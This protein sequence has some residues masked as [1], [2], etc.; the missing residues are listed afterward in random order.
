MSRG[1]FRDVSLEGAMAVKGQID[2]ISAGSRDWLS[3][4]QRQYAGHTLFK[5][6]TGSGLLNARKSRSGLIK[7]K[8]I[9][10]EEQPKFLMGLDLGRRSFDDCFLMECAKFDR[11]TEI[12]V[13]RLLKGKFPDVKLQNLRKKIGD[14]LG[15][16]SVS[17]PQRNALIVLLNYIDA[18]GSIVLGYS[19]DV[20]T[21]T[22][23]DGRSIPAVGWPLWSVPSIGSMWEITFRKR[24]QYISS[25]GGDI[26]FMLPGGQDSHTF[27]A[28]G[29]YTSYCIWGEILRQIASMDPKPNYELML[30]GIITHDI[31]SKINDPEDLRN[32]YVYHVF[33]RVYGMN[34]TPNGPIASTPID[35][36]TIGARVKDAIKTFGSK[37]LTMNNQLEMMNNQLGAMTHFEFAYLLHAG[38]KFKMV[39]TE[40]KIQS[41]VD[42]ST[43]RE[44]PDVQ[45]FC[46]KIR[47]LTAPPNL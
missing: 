46:D 43:G 4:Y 26:T 44:D 6:L 3:T 32:L 10:V 7:R 38:I 37:N 47:E 29:V 9:E 8:S 42:F 2:K 5:I 14:M 31:L 18:Q 25:Q 40:E 21:S 19:E 39:G 45:E 35:G 16:L 27:T 36:S 15:Q 33:R 12:Q 34:N 30:S 17:C 13:M 22:T 20:L 11:D 23:P 28:Q 41:F 1:T 24:V